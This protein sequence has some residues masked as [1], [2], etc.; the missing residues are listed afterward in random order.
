MGYENLIVGLTGLSFDDQVDEFLNCGADSVFSKPF[1]KEQMS[2]LV[3]H[4]RRKGYRSNPNL[5]WKIEGKKLVKHRLGRRPS[6][7]MNTPRSGS[8]NLTTSFSN[9]NSSGSSINSGL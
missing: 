6:V 3:Q 1:T 4:L 7:R 9:S 2:G 5:K 8:S